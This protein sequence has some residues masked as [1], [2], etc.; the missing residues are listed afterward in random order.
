V[1]LQ[2]AAAASPSGARGNREF[3]FWLSPRPGARAPEEL[4]AELP[5]E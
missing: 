3:F 2:R 5:L 4:V 1:F